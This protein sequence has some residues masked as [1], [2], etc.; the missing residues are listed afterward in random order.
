VIRLIKRYGSRKLYDTEESRYVS[1]EEIG[2]WVRGDQQVQVLDNQTGEDVTASTLTQVI[3]EEGKR[4]SSAISSAFL[5]DLIRRGEHVVSTG[6]QSLQ[7]GMDMLLQAGVDRVPPLR[8]LR[9][10]TQDLRQRLETLEAMIEDLEGREGGEA[11]RF[12]PNGQGER[13]ARLSARES[14]KS[15]AAR[16]AR[17]KRKGV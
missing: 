1:L 12:S 11:S 17:R 14:A 16:A 6:V 10:E 7:Q 8:Q 9:D 5:H 2:D 3:L 4:G 13:A 15:A